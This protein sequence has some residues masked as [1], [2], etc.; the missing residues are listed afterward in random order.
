MSREIAPRGRVGPSARALRSA[1]PAGRTLEGDD[2][3]G[4]YLLRGDVRRGAVRDF[5]TSGTSR[6]TFGPVRV[7]VG[8]AKGSGKV[9]PRCVEA[10]GRRKGSEE[11]VDGGAVRF[12]WCCGHG[13]RTPEPPS[14]G[15]GE[16]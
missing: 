8:S 6:R 9:A 14:L 11:S 7:A 16:R 10:Q 13:E 12:P 5:R 4:P 15:P 1:G 3:E 2:R